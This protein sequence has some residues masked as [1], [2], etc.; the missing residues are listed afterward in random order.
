MSLGAFAA[1]ICFLLGVNDI[2]FGA[3]VAVVIYLGADRLLKQIFIEKIEKLSEVT[4]TGIGA[5]IITWIFL[6]I[7]IFT[8][9]YGLA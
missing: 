6:W 1:I 8:F 9:F 2:F 3:M 7:L 5:Y 4:K